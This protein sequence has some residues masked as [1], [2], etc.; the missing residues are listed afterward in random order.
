MYYTIEECVQIFTWYNADCNPSLR[1]VSDLFRTSYPDRRTP[2]AATVLRIVNNFKRNGCIQS[3]HKK[4]SRPNTVLTEAKMNEIITFVQNNNTSSTKA[5]GQA[6]GVFE[7]T[8]Y[9]HGEVNS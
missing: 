7:A 3:Q 2:S 9:L 4:K 5:I 6:V 1:Q 8:F